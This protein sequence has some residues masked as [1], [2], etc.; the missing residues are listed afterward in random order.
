M[1]ILRPVAIILG[2]G[3]IAFASRPVSAADAPARSESSAGGGWQNLLDP[4]LTHWE[5][6]M[7]TPH[8]S[9]QGL[10]PGTPLSPDAHNGTPLGLGRDPTHVFTLVEQEGEPV[11][12]IT[13]EIFGGLTTKAEYGNYHLQLETQ[14]GAKIWE[15]KLTKPRDSGLLFHCTGEHGAFWNVWM[16]S[17]EFQIEQNNFGDLYCLVGT[18]ARMPGQLR[19]KFWTFQPGGEVVAVGAPP[20]SK[21]PLG[22]RSENFERPEGWNMV[23]LYALG[24]RAIYLVNGRVVNALLDIALIDDGVSRPLTRGK[25]QLQSEGAEIFYRRVRIQ[26]ITSIPR[27]VLRAA[28][29]EK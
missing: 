15:P 9:V 19:D 26:P 23:D 18:T 17:V 16:R 5:L 21:F 28:G 27:E 24:D 8:Q 20:S 12:H 7:G 13:G 6:W 1:P 10:P 22:K 25:L 11:L 29:L 2:V 3:L 14:W 4:S